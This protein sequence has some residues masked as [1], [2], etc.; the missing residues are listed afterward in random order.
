MNIKKNPSALVIG[1]ALF[2]M[3]FGSGNLIF[4]LL[5]GANYQ[6][7]FPI[8]TLGFVITA[9][10]LPSFGIL[11][12]VLA[13]G[14]YNKLF[15]NIMPKKYSQTLIFLILLFWI[16]FGSGPRCILLAHASVKT[17]ISFLPNI[18][19]FSLIFL[20]LV[21]FFIKNQSKVI[22]LLGK[23]LTPLL[24]L[25]IFLIV[26]ASFEKLKFNAPSYSM[27][28]VFFKSLISGYYTQDLIAAI[29]FSA[30][31]V[32]MLNHE[33][34]P[35]AILTKKIW[36]AGLIAVILLGVLYACLM[37]S[38]A[39]FSENLISLSGEQLISAL[40]QEALGATFGTI[41][42]VIV[43]LACFTTEIALVLV[44]TNFLSSIFQK[45]YQVCLCISLFLIWFM[46]LLDFSSLM[47]VIS[48]AMHVI[49]PILFILVL[50][51]LW[52]H[53]EKRAA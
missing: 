47:S 32:S 4:P 49:Y 8:A 21:Y 50:R 15:V 33:N 19:S 12:M 42:S 44:M 53:S 52:S 45:N 37:A 11:A 35:K 14:D 3:F 29:F 9:V 27:S 7:Y 13:G 23:I 28:E 43:F 5:L 38:S 6:G 48:F 25:S 26:F 30:T 36:Q 39:A 22:S 16:P 10:I 20:S 34:L 40:A 1:L 18:W 41:S 51:F 46:S 2:S 24:L 31:L 17:H